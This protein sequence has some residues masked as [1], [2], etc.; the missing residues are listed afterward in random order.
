MTAGET[1]HPAT[2]TGRVGP[3]SVRIDHSRSVAGEPTGGRPP[4]GDVFSGPRSRLDTPSPWADLPMARRQGIGIGTIRRAFRQR[5]DPPRVP[6]RP[7]IRAAA[8]LL[9]L[10]EEAGETRVVLIERSSAVRTH[11]GEIA[12]P[13]GVCDAGEAPRQAALRES[14]EEIGLPSTGVDLLGE[15]G[16]HTAELT[17]FQITPVVGAL[18]ARPVPRVNHS[19]VEDVFDVALAGLMADGVYREEWWTGPRGGFAVPFFDLSRGSVWGVTAS[20]LLELLVLVTA[21][22]RPRDQVPPPAGAVAP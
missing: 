11:R 18:A 13:G 19:E 16:G 5:E 9:T 8:V 15:L 21:S 20:M 1:G 12:F 10:F 3:D 22:A 17:R 7:G 2:A 14:W 6:Q 4:Y